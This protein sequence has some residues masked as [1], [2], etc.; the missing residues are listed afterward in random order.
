VPTP[1][2][3]EG[4]VTSRDSREELQKWFSGV[5]ELLAE[6]REHALPPATVPPPSTEPAIWKVRLSTLRR[7]LVGL[8]DLLVSSPERWILILC[9]G[10]HKYGRYVQLL[11]CEDGS[12]DAEASSN[13]FLEGSDR[14][15]AKEEAA[16]VAI[17]WKKPR[18]PGK[19]NWWAVQATVHPDT[20]EVASLLLATLEGVYGLCSAEM[21]TCRLF[22]SPKRGNT[23]ATRAARPPAKFVTPFEGTERAWRYRWSDAFHRSRLSPIV[24]VIAADFVQPVREVLRANG[25]AESG[26]SSMFDY[27]YGSAPLL[28]GLVISVLT[29]G[30]PAGRLSSGWRVLGYRPMRFLCLLMGLEAPRRPLRGEHVVATPEDLLEDWQYG[31]RAQ[32]DSERGLGIA[33]RIQLLLLVRDLFGEEY[34]PTPMGWDLKTALPAVSS[35][36]ALSGFNRLAEDEFNAAGIDVEEATAWKGLGLTLPWQVVTVHPYGLSTIETWIEAGYDPLTAARYLA[37]GRTLDQL[38]PYVAAGCPN[39]AIDKYLD[40][41]LGPEIVAEY[42]DAGVEGFDAANFASG[43][44]LPDAAKRWHDLGFNA[45]AA[46]R[47]LAA[48]GTIDDVLRLCEE[49]L[50]MM[51]IQKKLTA[52]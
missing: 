48:G 7:D 30:F 19:P 34:L 44:L 29:Y 31:A 16:L 5:D 36:W 24:F 45:Y 20:S 14:L 39:Y 50:S 38:A 49:G 51:E 6:Q 21:I 28:D 33:D 8:I 1:G 46:Q 26:Q 32:V 35:R 47:I 3:E 23:P 22:S 42:R 37:K 17:G 4:N 13:N 25:I 41:G 12:I 52:R 15:S 18:L 10:P 40:A 11:V 2:D 9:V 27:A 43:G